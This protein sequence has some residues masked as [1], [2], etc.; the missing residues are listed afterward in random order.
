[1]PVGGNVFK[2]NSKLLSGPLG[3]VRLGFEGYDLGFTTADSTLVP[4]QDVKD[5]MYQQ[6]GTKPA[7]HVRTGMEF[8]LNATFGEISTGLLVRL[9]AG[10]STSITSPVDDGGVLGRDLYESMLATEAGVLRVAALDNDGN[11]LMDTEHLMNFYQAIPIVN[12][13]LLNWG[14][15]TQ[16]NLPVQFR[17]KYRSF[18]AIESATHG[19]A[20]GYYGDPVPEDV[21]A[22]VW[23]DV[24]AP[25]LQATTTVIDA[26]DLDMIFNE[27]IA[28]QSAFAAGEYV[29]KVNDLFIVPASGIIATTTLTLTFPAASFATT[30]VVEIYA[31][32]IALEDTEAVPNAFGGV[33]GFSVLNPL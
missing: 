4:D 15:D 14:A 30:D 28:F 10:F 22:A 11:A 20:F 31:T 29:V 19:G 23:P 25:I 8:L 24:E 12:G 26:T 33:D 1:M 21:P 7:D 2:G 9:M 17:I 3:I 5:V 6:E 27:N 16:R 13:D 32:A 18:T